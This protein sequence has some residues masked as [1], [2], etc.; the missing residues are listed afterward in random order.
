MLLLLTL[1]R[2][3]IIVALRNIA[4]VSS[5][6]SANV[7]RSQWLLMAIMA[8]DGYC[9]KLNIFLRKIIIIFIIIFITK[10]NNEKI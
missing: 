2:F 5:V 7:S 4:S 10:T 8:I 3:N 9:Q 6:T 1:M